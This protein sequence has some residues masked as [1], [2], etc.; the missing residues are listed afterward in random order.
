MLS[1]TR[2]AADTCVV[3]AGL[4]ALLSAPIVTD[5][6]VVQAKSS[7]SVVGQK[8]SDAKSALSS[9]GFSAVVASTIGDR[10]A[11]ADCIVVN[12]RDRSRPPPPNS[13]ASATAE[14]LVALNCEKSVASATDPGNSRASPEGRAAAATASNKPSGPGR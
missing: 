3:A 9:A 2:L 14:T 10:S 8:Y 12:Q 11:W 7:P 1:R 13:G 4:T 5:C 6:A